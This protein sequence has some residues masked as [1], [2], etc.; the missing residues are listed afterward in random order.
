MSDFAALSPLPTYDPV[1]PASPW[2]DPP[3]PVPG[4]SDL[5]V[6]VLSGYGLNCQDETAAGF[7]MLGAGVE[8]VH[9]ADLL[10]RGLEGV[11]VLVFVGG[12]SFGDHIASGRV[13]ANLVRGRFGEA[14]LRFVD[15]G[16]LVLGICNGFQVLVKLG[17][18][19]AVGR[20]PL[21]PLAQPQATLEH[22]ARPG[23]RNAWVKLRIDPRS[24]CVFTRG[25]SET[26]L[27]LP[28]RH[29]EGQLVLSPSVAS[30]VRSQH[31]VPLYYADANGCPTEA[32][33]DNPNG[34]AG[35]MAGLCDATGRVFGLMPHPE[36]Y[37]YPENHPDWIAQRDAGALPSCGLGLG[38]LANGLRSLV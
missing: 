13:L 20:R 30:E 31:L 14:L 37:L 35:G 36:A 17:L 2:G 7:R 18:L 38:L 25:G 10:G 24:P 3:S 28:A 23:F 22:N 26:L 34:S 16:G 11:H 32:W 8:I 21:E 6:V 5:R 1:R 12:F 9:V 27:E 29:G 15:R 4:A 19:P 33:P